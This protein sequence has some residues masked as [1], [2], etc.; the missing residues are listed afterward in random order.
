MWLVAGCSNKET[1]SSKASN[2]L[3]HDTSP[4]L[5][6]HAYNPVNW[7]AWNPEILELAKKENKLLVISVGYS[8]CHWC[9]VMEE[10]SFEN[11]SIAKIMNDNFIN[12][13]VDREE[14]PDIDK[15]YMNAV[16]LM[17]GSGGWPL[18]CIEL[19]NGRP[20]F[21][22][23]YFT[24]EQWS[25]V[26]ISISTLYK[27]E[28]KKVIEFAENLTKGMQE[29]QLITLNKEAPVFNFNEIISSVNFLKSQIDT[30]IGGFKNAPKFPTPN[31]LDFLV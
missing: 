13:K 27:E 25:K 14:W 17:T 15:V 28:P 18:N 21:G 29:S 22:G 8:A 16:Q 30:I 7:K 19:P 3:I 5:L 20:I 23:T 9:H 2:A 11:D 12:I 10:E 4:Y 26:L 24:K 6:Q 31:S 1:V